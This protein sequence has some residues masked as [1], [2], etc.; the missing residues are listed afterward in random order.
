MKQHISTIRTYVTERSELFVGIGVVGFLVGIVIVV[1]LVNHF[2]GPNIVYQPV[3]ACELF[4]PDEAQDLLG[5]GVISVDTKEPIISE[6]TATS[7]CSYTDGNPNG[8]DTMVVAAVAIRSAINDEGV[9]QNKTDF[10]KAKSNSSVT[11]VEDMGDSAFF[12]ATLGQLNVYEDKTWTILSYG[13]GSAPE[14][15]TLEKAKELAR[16]V[17]D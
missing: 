14:T 2:S 7:K 9:S 1:A 16:I 10:S 12:N 5:D 6:T 13:L 17:L 3:K 4:T 11:N 15:N 8:A